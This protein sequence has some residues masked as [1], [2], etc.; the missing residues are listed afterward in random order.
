MS[1]DKNNKMWNLIQF[2]VSILSA[3]SQR[4]PSSFHFAHSD[5]KE[6]DFSFHFWPDYSSEDEVMS[7]P[8]PHRLTQQKQQISFLSRGN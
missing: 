4:I 2:P 8:S 5:I 7:L 1:R 6:D 3:F